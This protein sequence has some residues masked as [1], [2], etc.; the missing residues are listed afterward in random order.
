M[1]L[2]KGFDG[3]RYYKDEGPKINELSASSD[4]QLNAIAERT[5]QLV[6]GLDWDFG[7]DEPEKEDVIIKAL[8]VIYGD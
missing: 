1:V 7:E 8:S 3:F 4:R 5:I 2:K 6:D